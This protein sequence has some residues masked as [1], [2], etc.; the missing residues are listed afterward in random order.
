MKSLY[1]TVFLVLATRVSS[2]AAESISEKKASL[3]A[4]VVHENGD[5]AEDLR[6]VNETLEEK[7][8]ELQSLYDKGQLLLQQNAPAESFA[9]LVRHM[10][11][12]REEI[13]NIQ[14]MWR[15]EAVL[16]GQTDDYAL[17]QQPDTNLFQLVMDYGS[18]DYLYV[19]PTDIGLLHFSLYSSLP[20]PRESWGECLDLILA[21][22]GVGIRSLNPYVRE[23][24]LLS[25]DHA[26]IRMITDI[27]EQLDL[28]PPSARAC[29]ILDPAGGDAKT[30]LHV[31]KRFS[32]PTTL[33]I[34]TIGGKIFLTGT[35]QSIQELLKLYGFVRSNQGGH[36][37][38][39]VT[40]NKLD[41]K[42][43]ET[44]LNNAFC[45]ADDEVRTSSSLHILPLENLGQSLFLS[46]TRDELKK[47]IKLIQDVENQIEDPQEKTVFW[48]VAKHSDAEELASVLARVYDL[49][50]GKSSP[51]KDVAKEDKPKEK[52]EEDKTQD[53]SLLI[54]TAK[55][56]PK[57]A[58]SH[59]HRTADGQNNFIVDPKTGAIIM[60]VQ[61][62]ALPK[63][64]ELLKKLDVP[65][66]M[67]QIEV[68]LFEKKM[69]HQNNFG[70]NLLRLGSEALNRTSS[71]LIWNGLGA[72][73]ILDFF[74][75]RSKSNGLPAYDLAYQFLIGQEDIQINASPSIT[76]MNQTPAT[77]AIV[78]EM[79]IDSGG[80]GDKNK[81]SYSRAQYGI[82]MEITPTI[83]M[84]ESEDGETGFILLDTDITFDT[85]KKNPNDRPDVTRRHIKNH[86]R[87]ADGQTVILGGLRRKN[88][89]DAQDSIPFLGE[90]PGIGKLFSCSK[91]NDNST[92]MFVFITPKIINDPVEDAEKIKREELKKRP[93]DVPELLHSLLEAKTA[94]K[95]RLFEG[96]MQALFG[97]VEPTVTMTQPMQGEY[98]GR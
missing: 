35:V 89:E 46:G 56:A 55:V 15:K 36:E 66:K 23:L 18:S 5:F 32:H 53:S 43:M 74:T 73:G 17:W 34:E 82:V 37:C 67:I 63:I 41:A 19:I 16:I 81:S 98:D 29:Y 11:T 65:K 62:D 14:D 1:L 60:V 42:Q 3:D 31:L 22:Y 44:I 85:T 45:L 27:A 78:E 48:Y 30:A 7:R 38:Q 75:S 2:L 52:K 83:N 71:G 84:E 76:T 6:L 47:A 91:M 50:T 25:E 95:R 61:Q 12:L 77:I 87:I 10:Q 8:F 33:S 39:V 20:I 64:K 90:I 58:S 68:L 57:L 92:E 13:R 80:A 69:N 59:S 49:L 24:Y 4:K 40:L 26:T 28:L 72:G 9:P 88:I 94:Q 51:S 79:S 21:Q 96:S 54:K 70:L 97:R 86:V 93:G